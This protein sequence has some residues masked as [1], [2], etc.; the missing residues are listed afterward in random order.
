MTLPRK[1]WKRILFIIAGSLAALLVIERVYSYQNGGFRIAKLLSTQLPQHSTPPSEVDALLN[2]SF[3]FLG[4]GGTSF[5]FLGEDGTT[6]LKLFKH[7]HLLQ[8]SHWFSIALPGFSDA[9][10]IRK[11]LSKKTRHAHKHQAF[12]F[13]SCHIAEC[14]LK[15]ET[16]LLYLCLQPN[17]HFSKPVHLIDAWGISHEVDLSKTEFALQR[18]AELL[19]PHLEALIRAERKDELRRCIDSLIAQMQTRCHQGIGD[20]DPNLLINFG[21]IGE[22]AVEFDLGSFFPKDSLKNPIA[23]A[24]EI[25]LSTYA[26]RK[27]LEK[28]APELVDYVLDRI[29]QI[30]G[31]HETYP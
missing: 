25:F 3:R 31:L 18:K 1:A 14:A 15:E 29:M 16:G 27:W 22:K 12:F 7:Q 19:F 6:V 24:E 30:S 13:S 20:R 26:L 28:Q 11:I 21:F 10:R 23:A 4:K 2:Q 8:K 5:V 9:W 17:S